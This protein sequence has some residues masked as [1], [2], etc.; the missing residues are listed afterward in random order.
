MQIRTICGPGANVAGLGKHNHFEGCFDRL[1]INDVHIYFR[2]CLQL[3][4][5][6]ELWERRKTECTRQQ[7]SG[8]SN[9]SHLLRIRKV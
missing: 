2:Y 1:I 5:T 6:R 8:H 4:S 9:F 3:Y 7:S